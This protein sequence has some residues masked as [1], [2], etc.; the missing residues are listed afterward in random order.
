MSN[1]FRSIYVTLV[2]ILLIFHMH[3]GI[4]CAHIFCNIEELAHCDIF[5]RNISDYNKL[6]IVCSQMLPWCVHY[7]FLLGVTLS[8]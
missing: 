5:A 2:A 7:T 1:E 3:S 4:H 6:E 8:C